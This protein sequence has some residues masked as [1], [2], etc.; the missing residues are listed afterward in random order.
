[1]TKRQLIALLAEL[2]VRPNRKLGQNFL[3]DN[4]LLDAIVRDARPLPGERIL[5]IG[6]GTGSLTRRLL[7]AGCQVSA[8]ELDRRLANYLRAAF[9]D[10]PRLRL[11][12]ADACK[13]DYDA[14]MGPGAYR[15]IANLPY[16]GSSV[17]LAKMTELRNPPREMS[18]LLQLEMAARLAAAPGGKDFGALTVC[19]QLV[20]CVQQLRTIPAAVFHPSPE[21]DSALVRMILRQPQWSQPRRAMALE[22]ARIGFSQRRK[23]MLSLLSRRFGR[24]CVCAAFAELNIDADLR[25]ERM[26]VPG[27]VDLAGCLMEK[28]PAYFRDTRS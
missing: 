26:T 13:V 18:V 7:A 25:A 12:E 27:F 24:E 22:I 1:M 23:K 20:Y 6:P 28:S 11:T 2:G 3:V 21:V 14:L 8:V 19:V 10:E 9:S 5:E 17:M 15:C 16:A 4:N